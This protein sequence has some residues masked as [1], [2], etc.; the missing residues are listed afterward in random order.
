MNALSIRRGGFTLL[1][2]SVVIAIMAILA[3]MF[4]KKM[5][6]YQVQVERVAAQQV[7]VVLRSAL[8]M[9]VVTLIAQG[10]QSE[11]ASLAS[12]NP[13][14][15]LALKPENYNG[16]F[17]APA[18]EFIVPGNWYFDRSDMKLIYFYSANNF[19]SNMY[20]NKLILKVKL[21]TIQTDAHRKRNDGG[22]VSG[23]SL[24]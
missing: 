16:E 2:I 19:S 13:M 18:A 17:Y 15:W 11:L 22:M 10:R 23:V 20:E 7:V 12:Q 9:Q 24:E 6:F 14:D 1:E 3:A 8:H 21:D 5:L 4:L